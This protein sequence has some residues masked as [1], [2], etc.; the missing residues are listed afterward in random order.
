MQKWLLVFLLLLG[1]TV[2]AQRG[3]IFVKKHGY[4]KVHS[5]AEGDPISFQIKDGY[6]VSG[7]I[8]LVRNDSI[9]V[10]GTP[11]CAC[12]VSKI[13][14]RE[15]KHDL[16]RQ[17]LL[18]TGYVLVVAGAA[19]LS[20]MYTFGSA[21]GISA[22]LGYGQLLIRQIPNLKRYKYKIGKKFS[23]QTLDLHF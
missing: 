17:I 1:Q 21:L 22:I 14:L 3:M 19:S 8:S 10:S 15:K 5:F 7:Y 6:I 13:I 16:P 18:S 20:K 11:F 12:S 2:M 9:Y 23:I 4:K